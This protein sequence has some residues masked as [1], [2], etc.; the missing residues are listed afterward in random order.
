[1]SRLT[2]MD[3]AQVNADRIGAA[4][5]YA[6]RWGSVVTLKGAYTAI[7]SQYGRALVSPF[8]NPGLASAGTGDVLAGAIAGLMAQGV[9]T[10]DAAICGVYLHGA[11]GERVRADLGKT[12][13]TAPDLLLQIPRAISDLRG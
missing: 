6:A 12:G 1:M 11:A 9:S 3:I 8:A 7:G 10:L 2:G 5:D 4:R 13:M